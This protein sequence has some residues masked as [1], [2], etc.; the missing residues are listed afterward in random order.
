PFTFERTSEIFEAADVVILPYVESSGSGKLLLA[1][2]F[3]K[4]IAATA[5]GGMDEY[6][7]AYP[8]GSILNELTPESVSQAL[9]E[10][11]GTVRAEGRQP[12]EWDGTEFSWRQIV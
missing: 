7:S 9:R 12:F 3:G 8:R 10:L 4:W 1:M 6:L 2:T 5:T 11:A